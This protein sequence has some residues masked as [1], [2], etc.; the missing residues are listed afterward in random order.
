[1]N[2]TQAHDRFPDDAR[3]SHSDKLLPCSVCGA[4]KPTYCHYTQTRPGTVSVLSFLGQWD[5]VDLV[6]CTSCGNEVKKVNA[7]VGDFPGGLFRAWNDAYKESRQ[8]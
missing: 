2:K 5:H 3:L 7:V 4:E 6:R 1:M 8:A